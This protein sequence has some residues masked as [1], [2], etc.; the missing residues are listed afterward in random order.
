MNLLIFTDLDGTLL[1]HDSYSFD[2]AQAAL[3][4]LRLHQASLIFT[5]SKTRF[6]IERLQS[7]VKICEP[8]ISENG[9]A[10]FFPDGYRNFRMNIGFR[11][12]PYTVIHTGGVTYSEIRRF[13]YAVKKRFKLK[14]FG[15][16]SIKEIVL[17]TGLTQEQAAMAKMREF[18]ESFLVD[19]ESKLDELAVI[20][21]SQGFKITVGG[22]FSH[23]IGIRQD[24]DRAVR[25]CAEIF[26]QNTDGGIVTVG[27]GDSAND[28]PMLKSVDIPILLPRDDGTYEDIDFPKIIRADRP[29]SRGWN[30]AI[31]NVFNSLKEREQST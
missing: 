5:T 20:A 15:D 13:V 9:A 16:L 19:E 21:A 1:D 8:F 26:D 14:G 6:E 18:T 27:L 4:L 28:I 12:P 7:A 3:E 11:S 22:R 29:G 31:L 17:Y 25:L 23:L 30:H 24:K 10:I 2:A